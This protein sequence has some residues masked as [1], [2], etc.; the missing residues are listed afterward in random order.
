MIVARVIGWL[1]VAAV[2]ASAPVRAAAPDDVIL[3]PGK[4]GLILIPHIG[5][6]LSLHSGTM[7]TSER[8]EACCSFDGGAGVGL[9]GGVRTFIPWLEDWQLSPR[10]VLMQRG[11]A[12]TAESARLPIR[13]AGNQLEEAVLEQK[14]T[15]SR[16]TV[17]LDALVAYLLPDS[18]GYVLGGP[19]LQIAAGTDVTG[20]E[21][22][23]DPAGVSFLDGTR[24]RDLQS[25]ALVD[26]STV[27]LHLVVGVGTWVHVPAG[28]E[29]NPELLV[30]LP[31]SGATGGGSWKTYGV[32]LNIGVG[33]EL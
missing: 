16:S 29:I 1:I 24:V 32:S 33:F 25:P 2:V 15:L 20:Q 6:M 18:R 10:V 31:L 11:G 13:G 28:F 7:P 17:S 12:F 14:L 21:R 9:L 22:I 30:D 26:A 23:I 27:S 5:A 19:A 4:P 8:G 3:F